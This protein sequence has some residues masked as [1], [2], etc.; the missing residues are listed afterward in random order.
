MQTRLSSW[1]KLLGPVGQL[2]ATSGAAVSSS[3]G[4]NVG[5]LV[6]A[7][8]PHHGWQSTLVS[9]PPSRAP[10]I[11]LPSG[12]SRTQWKLLPL[13]D[14]LAAH[15]SG[16]SALNLHLHGGHPLTSF[17]FVYALARHFGQAQDRLAVCLRG[18]ELVAAVPL[19]RQTMR[20][21][22]FRPSQT[23]MSPLLVSDQSQ[24]QAL[25]TSLPGLVLWLDL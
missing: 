17:D 2:G 21:R 18:R 14:G 19:S 16:W 11:P 15:R 6:S 3:A 10:A 8:M 5:T 20:W 25:L 12:R 1:A 7:R 13:V 22:S 9:R 4:A 23:E 24:L